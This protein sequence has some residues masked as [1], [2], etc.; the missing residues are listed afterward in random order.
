MRTT[1]PMVV[2][3][4]SPTLTSVEFKDSSLGFCDWQASGP[5]YLMYA[6]HLPS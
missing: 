2:I 4:D 3:T 6:E 1:I 5:V